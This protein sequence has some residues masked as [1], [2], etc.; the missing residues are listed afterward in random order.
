MARAADSLD[1]IR[2]RA[3]LPPLAVL[4][5][6]F[7]VSA[8]VSAINGEAPFAAICGFVSGAVLMRVVR[9]AV[10]AAGGDNA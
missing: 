9:I 6:L 4:L 10:I 8:I 5:A 2:A 3:N 7:G 1:A